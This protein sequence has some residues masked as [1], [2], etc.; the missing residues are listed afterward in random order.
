[1]DNLRAQMF[2]DIKQREHNI[3]RNVYI[4]M[5]VGLALTAVVALSVASSPT[6][7]SLFLRN[8]TTF[9]FVIIAQFVVVFYLTARLDKM[10]SNKAII[11]FG[12]YS[13]LTG[14][15]LSTLFY[16]YSGLVISRAF[17]TTAAVFGGMSFYGL[18]TKRDL[19]GIGHYLIMGL[20][21][22]II[23]SVINIFLKSEP[24]Y[25]LLSIV[26]VLIFSALT[27]WDTQKIKRLN[28]SYGSDIDEETY[29]KLSIIGAL[30]LYLDFINIFLYLIRLFGNR[31]K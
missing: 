11:A 25:Y 22:I 19:D 24:I 18:V 10:S 15:T 2:T 5:T 7:L 29:I 13:I 9:L 27:A 26:G 3:L 16:A 17:F 6:L 20:W 4:W 21:G 8:G 14:I 30:M 28:E 1:M 12:A 31:N 23:A